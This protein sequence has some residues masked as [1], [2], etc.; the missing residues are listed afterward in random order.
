MTVDDRILLRSIS[1]SVGHGHPLTLP[2]L[3]ALQR[4]AP[5]DA[6]ILMRRSVRLADGMV[7]VGNA[8]SPAEASAY[9]SI[10]KELTDLSATRRGRTGAERVR[11]YVARASDI[12]PIPE[13]ADLERR[14]SCRSDL[15]RFGLTYCSGILDHPPSEA[16]Q[17]FIRAMQRVLL[18]GGKLHV[19]W[20][21]GKG[22][23]T[24]VK[25]GSLWAAAFGHRRF[26]V[27]ISATADDAKEIVGDIIDII[28]ASDAFA[29]DFP[30]IGYPI[31]ALEGVS[32]RCQTQH[33]LGART[34]I[35]IRDTKLVMPTVAGAP[36][37]G[38]IIRAKGIKGSLRGMVKG[39]LRPD[40][41]YL[42]DP[43]TRKDASSPSEVR[44]FLAVVEGDIDGLAG[45]RK[46]M[47]TIFATTPVCAGDGSSQLA[48][49]ERFPNIKTI[50]SPLIIR[51][52]D[53]IDL[54]EEFT[55]LYRAEGIAGN[56][57][58]TG[59]REFYRLHRPEMDRG[60]VVLDPADGDPQT[61]DSAIH[62]AMIKRATMSP[63]AFDA[64]YQ[65]TVTRAAS[66][67][68]LT[69]ALML[70]HVTAIPQFAVPIACSGGCVAYCDVNAEAGLR[71]GV[72][73]VGPRNLTHLVAYGRYPASG[74]LL[75]EASSEAAVAAAVAR[76]LK[77][78]AQHIAALPLFRNKHR[79][80]PWALCFDGGWQTRTVSAFCQSVR[81]PMKVL[82][83]KGFGGRNYRPPRTS[84]LVRLGDNCHLSESVDNGTFL[85]VNADFW[86]EYAQRAF[87]AA[88]MS[89]GGISIFDGTP[90]RHA[91][92]IAECCAERLIDKTDGPDGRPLW[93]WESSGPNHYGDVLSGCFALA[94]WFGLLQ[95]ARDLVLDAISAAPAQ[96]VTSPVQT[97][98]QS[99]RRSAHPSPA[100]FATPFR[101]RKK[102]SPL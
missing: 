60:A 38:A 53:R 57:R 36:S 73:A 98:V 70:T 35:E 88:P 75:P 45:H 81:A 13:P 87:L 83:S 69:P 51:F 91:D 96:S 2:Q 29:E 20:P 8:L 47:S 82:W 100:R 62:H 4:I 44:K 9:A 30:E 50:T 49:P 64:E 32:Q 23:T 61:E 46:Q 89:P 31:R 79:I 97:P 86:R 55:R 16:M 102:A 6:E 56:D 14:E 22:K 3:E 42:D 52:P 40:F 21:R 90:E 27:V 71:W 59:S 24:W 17:Q 63:E 67:F 92:L 33:S 43:Q 41:V 72:L 15:V 1:E 68:E 7:K 34:K 66:L 10:R 39:S 74:R 101:R 85:A 58:H 95:P 18:E 19:R 76:G 25:I 26:L 48:D 37:S 77:A 54:W 28:E 84:A 93:R 94:S 5:S 65:M 99:P 80:T 78:V 11:D 12:G